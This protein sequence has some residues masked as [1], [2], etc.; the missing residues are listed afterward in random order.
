RIQE[1]SPEAQ[2]AVRVTAVGGN[3]TEHALIAAVSDLE[4]QALNRAM[5]EACESV[6]LEADAATLRY[7]F[8]HALVQEAV[9]SD[10]LPGEAPQWHPAF[11][12]ILRRRTPFGTHV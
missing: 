1:L 5:R 2:L 12:R 10:L 3:R 7:G 8:R 9:Y 11:A 4:P 6:V